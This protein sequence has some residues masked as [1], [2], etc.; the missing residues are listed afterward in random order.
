MKD[1]A[2][3][4]NHTETSL[5][6][7]LALPPSLPLGL[8]QQT[9]QTQETHVGAICFMVSQKIFLQSADLFHVLWMSCGRGIGHP[10][11]PLVRY[12]VFRERGLSPRFLY[13]FQVCLFPL[14]KHTGTE[15]STKTALK[16][17]NSATISVQY[18]RSY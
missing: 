9:Q 7:A 5:M 8:S 10:H 18:Q 3:P 6:G 16:G 12:F 1:T 14:L 17:R 15:D 4:G 11:K 13:D 2:L